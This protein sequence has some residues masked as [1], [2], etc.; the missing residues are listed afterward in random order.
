MIRE[1]LIR[2]VHQKRKKKKVLW[3]NNLHPLYKGDKTAPF[4]ATAVLCSLARCYWTMGPVASANTI[5]GP[6][7]LPYGL[8]FSPPASTHTAAPGT[9][10]LW[11]LSSKVVVV[12][13]V[14]LL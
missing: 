7:L 11:F 14:K 8:S 1:L 13:R 3:N 4:Q 12:E 6:L 2:T 10:K 9:A 5:G